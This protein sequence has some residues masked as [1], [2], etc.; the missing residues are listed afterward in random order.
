M[1]SILGAPIVIA[2][3]A[4]SYAP[5]EWD[6][7]QHVITKLYRDERRSL[8]DVQDDIGPTACFP[9]D[10]SALGERGRT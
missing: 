3:P 5:A 8:N 6:K 2:P 1:A 10:E 4:Q 9:A 7:Y